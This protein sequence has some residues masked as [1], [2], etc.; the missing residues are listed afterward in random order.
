M[1]YNRFKL[2]T[3]TYIVDAHPEH[4]LT[5][6]TINFFH[7]TR[8]FCL[9]G[10]VQKHGTLRWQGIPWRRWE[11]GLQGER[12]AVGAGRVSDRSR[13]AIR[14][15]LRA[16][17]AVAAA[18]TKANTPVKKVLLLRVRTIAVSFQLPCNTS[19]RLH[20]TAQT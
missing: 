10:R 11:V 1:I 3:D 2:Q 4:R 14:A 18:D 17:T 5:R 8:K 19:Q 16:A 6:T 12:G 20:C 9:S 13:Y 7:V 15:S